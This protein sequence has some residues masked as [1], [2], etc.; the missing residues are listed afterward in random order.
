[1][2]RVLKSFLHRII[3]VKTYY[4]LMIVYTACVLFQFS[5]FLHF[6]NGQSHFNSVIFTAALYPLCPLS[7]NAQVYF[8]QA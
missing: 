3:S 6:D 5:I 4:R 8:R 1:M 7:M 2:K